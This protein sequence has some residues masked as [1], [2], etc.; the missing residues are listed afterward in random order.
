ME[1]RSLSQKAAKGVLWSAIERFSAQGITLV[2]GILIARIL[3]PEDYG[4]IAMLSIFFALCSAIVDSGFST[5]LIRKLNR[6]E[7]DVST[8]FYFN[9]LIGALITALFYFSAPWIASFYNE[10]LLIPVTRVLSFTVLIGSIGA[11]QQVKLTI[12][13]DFK[14]QAKVSITTALLSGGV[15]LW[16]AYSGWGIWALVLQMMLSTT[17]RT[18]LL[19]VVERWYPTQPFSKQSFKEL[20][21][22]GSKLLIS[23]VIVVINQNMY[24]LLVGKLLTP[25]ALGLYSRANQF[26]SFPVTNMVFIIQRVTLPIFSVMQ[27]D[28]QQLKESVMKVIRLVVWLSFMVMVLILLVA[29]PL[30]VLLLTDKWID[31]VVPLQILSLALAIWPLY[32]LITNVL[33]VKG[34]S[35]YVMYLQ[36]IKI[37]MG[38][39]ILAITYRFGLYY[40]C[41]G[42]LVST[43]IVLFFYLI[44]FN[45]VIPIS[46][47]QFLRSI[48]PFISIAGVAFGIAYI[49]LSFIALLWLQLLVGVLL[50]VATYLGLTLLFL[51]H[52]LNDFI[53]LIKQSIK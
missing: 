12:K 5:A 11:I 43:I 19:W 30:I 34:K 38:L 23:E 17:L 37:V 32:P 39:A 53:S 20:F 13:I 28:L 26:A 40:I 21:G 50:F 35:N 46:M 42:Q 52:D 15:A 48:L 49:V 9:I 47:K 25:V 27:D 24:T 45:K 8:V 10:P 41:V 6:T 7:S 44:Y 51:K 22:F 2:L 3:T 36:I 18:L 14:K 1:K 16:A 33:N 31:A 29:K 4:L